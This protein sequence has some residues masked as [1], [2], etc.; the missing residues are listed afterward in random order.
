MLRRHT[1]LFLGG[2][3]LLPAWVE[4][5]PPPLWL[6]QMYRPGL[7]LADYWVSEKF[8]GV[9]GYWDGTALIS[10]GGERI[11]APAWFTQGWPSTPM[12]GELWAGRGRFSHAQSTTC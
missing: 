1:M 6:A 3:F 5:A 9:R 4:A 12:D 11:P 10:R 7:P 8:D 2:G